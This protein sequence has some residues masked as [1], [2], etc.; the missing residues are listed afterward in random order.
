[1]CR[2]M[3]CGTKVKHATREDA[4]AHLKRLVWTNHYQRQDSRSKGLG[5]YPCGQCGAFHVGH[6][7]SLP[8]V[9]HYTIVTPYLERISASDA[10]K[11]GRASRP[12]RR[13]LDRLT[14][15]LRAFALY[16]MSEPE[17]LLW[18]SR[19]PEWDYSVMKIRVSRSKRYHEFSEA[20]DPTGRAYVGRALTE[21]VG[22]GLLRFG[23]RPSLAKLRWSDYLDRNP[24][25]RE[26]RYAMTRY[27]NPTEWL[28]TDERVPL[29]EVSAIEVYYRGAWVD[30]RSISG[31]DFDAYI[32]SRRTVYSAA[33]CSL[34]V[35]GTDRRL[36][37]AERILVADQTYGNVEYV[38]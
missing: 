27:G 11:P 7:E 25:T 1:M 26:L 20:H 13:V 14:P 34:K 21:V 24:T 10:L 22:E 12:P 33:Q 16:Y 28:A 9:W 37:E 31:E 38:W 18:F 23:V 36:S 17:P 19:N 32:E 8:L 5:V 4:I 30:V 3:E 2:I 29:A 6:Q 15:E 35:Q